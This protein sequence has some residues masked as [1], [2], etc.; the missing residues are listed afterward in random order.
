MANNILMFEGLTGHKNI[1]KIDTGLNLPVV[2]LGASAS[3]YYPAVGD[4]LKCDL[5]LPEHGDVANAIGAVVGRITMRVQG[6]VTAPNEGQFRVHLP[7]GPKDFLNE[8]N[9]LTCL[10]N[11]LL[12][13]AVDQ[14]RASGAADI[15]TNVFRDIKKAKVEA[16]QIFVEALVTVEASGRPRI[17]K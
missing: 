17:S 7:D 13:Q 12:D 11:F 1:V 10:E 15:V 5:I 3:S 14:A 6:S 8:K 2:G 16:R 9:A 4:L